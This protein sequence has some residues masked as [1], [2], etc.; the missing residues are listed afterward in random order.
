MESKIYPRKWIEKKGKI[1]KKPDLAKIRED[2]GEL[3][4][5][6]LGRQH[7]QMC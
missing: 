7:Y 3:K 2:L 1:M 6:K 4:G 5:F